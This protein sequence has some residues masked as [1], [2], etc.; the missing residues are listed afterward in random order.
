MAPLLKTDFLPTSLDVAETQF[1]QLVT[2][3]FK[4]FNPTISEK[5]IQCVV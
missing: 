2:T 3:R 4:S 5:I 1:R